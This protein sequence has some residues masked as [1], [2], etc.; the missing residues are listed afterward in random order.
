MNFISQGQHFNRTNSDP[1]I[2]VNWSLMVMI[3]YIIFRIADSI[4]SPFEIL[5]Y[6]I[7]TFLW[8]VIIFKKIL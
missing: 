2:N 6:N 5:I 4:L 7:Q 1:I 8:L 3:E